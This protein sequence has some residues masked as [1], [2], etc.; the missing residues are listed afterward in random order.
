[1]LSWQLS[2]INK[3]QYKINKT[4][5]SYFMYVFINNS[6]ITLFCLLETFHCEYYWL[7]Y[8]TI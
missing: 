8:Y 6:K 5:Q 3:L 4:K 2:R 1:M 7:L